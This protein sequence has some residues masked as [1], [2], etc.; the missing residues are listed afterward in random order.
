M[1]GPFKYHVNGQETEAPDF[2]EPAASNQGGKDRPSYKTKCQRSF[3]KSGVSCQPLVDALYDISRKEYLVQDGR[4]VWMPQSESQFRRHCRM[5]GISAKTIEG[6][7]YSPFDALVTKLQLERSVDFVGP[8]AGYKPGVH[9]EN[10]SRVLVTKGPTLVEP[11]PGKFPLLE[12]VLKNALSDA[13]YDQ[14]TFF[15]GWLAVALRALYAERRVPGQALV[16][17][18]P[19]NAGKSLL[20]DIITALMGGRQ[21]KPYSFMTGA[22]HFNAHLARAEHLRIG[23]ENPLT[24]M[25]SRRNF[26]AQIKNIC[27]EPA[28][29]IEAKY[30]DPITLKP[31]WRLTISLNDEPENLLVLPPLDEHTLDKLML[32]KVYKREMP[33]PT[34]TV[35]QRDNFW[36]ALASEFPAYSYWLL[37]I[38]VIPE[39][40]ACQRFGIVHFHHPEIT[41]EVERFEAY[42]RLLAMIDSEIFGNGSPPFWEGS[43]EELK[44]ELTRDVSDCAR[45]ARQLLDWNGSTARYLGQLARAHPERVERRHTEY[46]RRW[47]IHPP[48][49]DT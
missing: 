8:I 18:G 31:F 34:A 23:D 29:N 30:R 40:S 49:P 16:L 28:Q 5:L 20:Q 6:A 25:R 37:N 24:D 41:V 21:A 42:M 2:R 12:A 13:E 14:I 3:R 32:L 44:S 39:Q 10:T 15:H 26:G 38:F 7:Y 48:S 19:A 35:E 11:K 27:V 45:E 33:M 43:A 46:S 36:Q 9:E 47:R 22:T 1:A 4:G 17:V